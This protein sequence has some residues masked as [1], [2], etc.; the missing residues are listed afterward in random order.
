M[1]FRENLQHLR[2]SRNMT[3]EQLAMLVGV[4]R[5]SVTKWEAE[6][7]YPEMDKL[8]KI[9]DLFDVSLDD[10]VKGDLTE[11][12]IKTSGS[13]SDNTPKDFVGYDEHMRKQAL[14]RSSAYAIIIAGF[15]LSGIVNTLPFATT[16]M[17]DAVTGAVFF[18]GLAIG[19]ALLLP[20]R[21]SHKSFEA[22]HPFVEDFYSQ[23]EKD[24]AAHQK[25]IAFVVGL[26]VILL[27]LIIGA[28]GN[29]TAMEQLFGSI[30]LLFV[31]LGV[32]IM[33]YWSM[34]AA[35]TNVETYNVNALEDLSEDE[36]DVVYAD[37]AWQA[38]RLE[39]RRRKKKVR[40]ISTVIMLV[41]TLIALAWL[42]WPAVTG[43]VSDWSQ[44][45]QNSLFW[46]PWLF[47]GICCFIVSTVIKNQETN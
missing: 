4:S 12:D 34:L 43:D 31:A 19:I 44:L 11:L 28:L 42:F 27:G 38:H 33:K 2:A 8:I 30:F 32:W 45:G 3:Q 16:N 14:R 25:S 21:S 26:A 29:G 35:R 24:K 7:S 39:L 13:T 20:T 47:G 9:C 6:Q 23:E 41:A 46:L 15:A 22:A 5:Q 37:E 17:S 1:S 40:S 10:L 18:I 36:S